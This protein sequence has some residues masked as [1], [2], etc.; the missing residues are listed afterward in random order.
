MASPHGYT[1]YA[2]RAPADLTPEQR[3]A[4]ELER[5]R[6]DAY[7]PS[8][9]GPGPDDSAMHEGAESPAFEGQEDDEME[10]GMSNGMS[11]EEDGASQEDALAL[12]IAELMRRE[13]ERAAP[14]RGGV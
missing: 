3:V 13:Q 9:D 11:D 12:L 10:E 5:S 7:A 6:G 4:L 2:R 8:G 1:N 14:M